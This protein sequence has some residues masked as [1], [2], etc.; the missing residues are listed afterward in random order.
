[1]GITLYAIISHID[2]TM[3]CTTINLGNSFE[4]PLERQ[5]HTLLTSQILSFRLV[6]TQKLREGLAQLWGMEDVGGK[7]TR[8]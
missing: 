2:K 3:Q 4:H 7:E 5:L 1:M 6:F 8:W